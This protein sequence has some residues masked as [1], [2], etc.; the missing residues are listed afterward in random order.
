MEER[1][2]MRSLKATATGAAAGAVLGTGLDFGLSQVGQRFA[3]EAPA[4]EP[5]TNAT[6]DVRGM[7]VEARKQLNQ[8]YH[9]PLPEVAPDIPTRQVAGFTIPDEPGML[10]PRSNMGEVKAFAQV[11]SRQLED[12]PAESADDAIRG[13]MNSDL[14]TRELT[15]LKASVQQASN[16]LTHRLAA[17]TD[18]LQSADDSVLVRLQREQGELA[19]LQAKMEQF[20]SILRADS[21]RNLRARQEFETDLNDLSFDKIREVL[22]ER[23]VKERDIQDAVEQEFMRRY[24]KVMN[25]REYKEQTRQLDLDLEKALMNGDMQE[26]MRIAID[27]RMVRDRLLGEAPR[28]THSWWHKLA[29]G[30]I[31]NVFSATTLAINLVPSA[32]KG[33]V[34]PGLKALLNNPA[35]KATRAEAAASYGAMKSSMGAAWRAAKAAWRY[36]QA[37]MSH[38]PNR[39]LESHLAMGGGKISGKVA[40]HIRF[41]LRGINATDEFLTRIYYNAYVAGK[42]AAQA[43]EEGMSLGYKGKALDA[44]IKR[45]T[46]TAL[47]NAYRIDNTEA[48]LDPIIKKG[49]NLGLRGKALEKY[50][51]REAARDPEILVRAVDEEGLDYIR[52]VLYKR[53]FSGESGLSYMALKTEDAM[54]KYPLLKLVSGQLFFRT[55]IRVIEEGLRLTPGLNMVLPNGF[56]ADLAGKNGLNRQI[57]ARAEALISFTFAAAAATL[58]AEGKAT[59]DGAYG[60]W[61]QQR[62]QQ[63]SHM[64]DPYTIKMDDGSTWNYR[65][66]D[67][68]A[69][70]MKIMFNAFERL[71]TLRIREAQGEFVDKQE[72]QKALS[73]LTVGTSAVISA[74][75]DANLL[76]GVDQMIENLEMIGN[77]E[78]SNSLWVKNF[79][80]RIRLLVPNTLHKASRYNDPEYRAPADF[81]QMLEQQLLRPVGLGGQILTPYSYDHLG[82]RRELTDVGMLFNIFSRA[83][84]EEREKGRSEQELRIDAE[85]VRLQRETG[86]ILRYPFQHPS[87][88]DMDLRTVATADGSETLF[89]KWNR[90]FNEQIPLDALE[91]VLFSELPEGTFKHKAAK[92]ERTREILNNARERAFQRMRAEE[93]EALQRQLQERIRKAETDAGLWDLDRQTV[94]QPAFE[95]PWSQ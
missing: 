35:Q 27:K 64:P 21:G 88:G 37:I 75:R 26:A 67:P 60:D 87:T 84:P 36:E 47:D 22:R 20:D 73:A 9:T 25:S 90:Y 52:E 15:N 17:V 1:D 54:N 13:L 42:A 94:R 95:T 70:P 40:P 38:D 6:P 89:D 58:W 78:D 79:G 45:H 3:R 28:H 32:V 91:A 53:G 72:Y 30:A 16:R 34:I 4:V 50:I 11:L 66:F 8:A 74:V 76:T 51:R 68:I 48:I 69:T 31:S 23:G 83:T 56:H 61:R 62:L 12:L 85:L 77:P 24:T 86:L 71:D 39:F 29:E 41:F 82:R 59:G 5:P 80:E 49:E 14:S 7:S 63:D 93:Q 43:A 2:G 65:F 55:P 46:K 33:L 19:H 44:Y 10:N 92:V 57:K 18:M 81:A